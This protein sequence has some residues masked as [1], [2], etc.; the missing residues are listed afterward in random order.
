M[1]KGYDQITGEKMKIEKLKIFIMLMSFLSFS[2]SAQGQEKYSDSILCSSIYFIMSGAYGEN[3]QAQEMIMSLQ[4]TH[5]VI[6][7][8]QQNGTIT[9]GQISELKHHHLVHLGKLYDS[10]PNKIYELEMQCNQWREEITPIVISASQKAK[11]FDE[12]KVLLKT[13]PMMEKK[14]YGPSDQRWATS[15]QMMDVGFQVWDQQDRMTPFSFKEKLRK[16]IQN[17]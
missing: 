15:K 1:I 2:V 14:P 12:M 5:E 13:I 3:K 6:Y 17:N 10:N 16:S 11:N 7:A 9:N 8:S 4:Q